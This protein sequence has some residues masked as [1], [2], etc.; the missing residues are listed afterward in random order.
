M[1][2]RKYQ[3]RLSRSPSSSVPKEFQNQLISKIKA[4]GGHRCSMR[5]AKNA[6][7][8]KQTDKAVVAGRSGLCTSFDQW[9]MPSNIDAIVVG[10]STGGPPV[11][12]QIFT[13]LP[14]SLP[15]PIIVAQHIPELFTQSLA[16]RLNN[17]CACGAKLAEHGT[18]MSEPRIYI[19]QGGKHMKPTLVAGKNLIA[20]TL[21]KL[22]GASYKPSVNLLFSTAADLFG[23]RVLAIQLTGM[24]QDGAVGAKKIRAKGGHVIAQNEE[25]C[26][27]F[28]MPRAV[29]ENGSANAVMSPE[30][31]RKV[32]QKICTAQSGG[33][34]DCSE[35]R[36][37]A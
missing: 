30:D 9:E 31:I 32:L 2:L 29:I 23:S 19:S 37:I 22:D 33:V 20:R 6:P 16:Q 25:S 24:G 35:E 17:H 28:G 7:R 15:V 26:V 34:L 13:N 1:L 10:S 14:A 12:E 8:V 11:L 18:N 4:I 3:V 21:D 5:K 27:V 36:K